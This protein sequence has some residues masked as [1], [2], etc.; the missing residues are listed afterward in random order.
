M[1]K[2]QLKK[3]HDALQKM[4]RAAMEDM[5]NKQK[6]MDEAVDSSDTGI[7]LRTVVEHAKSVTRFQTLVEVEKLLREHF[8][9]EDLM[10]LTWG[11]K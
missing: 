4:T 7:Q 5:G 11:D 3:T 10:E 2:I 6:E 9:M 1:V 8:S